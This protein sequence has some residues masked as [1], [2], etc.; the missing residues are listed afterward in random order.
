M[1]LPWVR[2][3][4]HI[5]R[6]V[7]AKA[8]FRAARH[9]FSMGQT[10]TAASRPRFARATLA[11]VREVASD[12]RAEDRAELEALGV[13]S[14]HTHLAK[15]LRMDGDMRAILDADGR[16]V[17]LFGVAINGAGEAR[18]AAP[19]LICGAG[20]RRA[21]RLIVRH[22]PRW[23]RAYRRAFGPMANLAFGAN[24]T[25]HRLIEHCGFSWRGEVMI[26]GHE[27]RVFEHV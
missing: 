12:L 5:K 16:C 22:L 2:H 27:F 11:H 21:R 4:Y 26:S 20:Y 25:H 17:G 24:R 8:A 19:W 13:T 23:V 1:G 15:P 7:A 10:L 9:A 18:I 14:P 3:V 6:G